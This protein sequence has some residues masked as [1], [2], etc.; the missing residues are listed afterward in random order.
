MIQQSNQQIDELTIKELS[1]ELCYFRDQR[2]EPP[3]Q[4]MKR[5]EQENQKQENMLMMKIHIKCHSQICDH[6]IYLNE[7][8]KLTLTRRRFNARRRQHPEAR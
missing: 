6:L 7:Y 1:N 4:H 8:M 3:E 2:T 5:K